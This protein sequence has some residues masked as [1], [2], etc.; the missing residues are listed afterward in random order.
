MF[1]DD[2]TVAVRDTLGRAGGPELNKTHSGCSNGTT[3]DLGCDG[4]R[5]SGRD[6]RASSSNKVRWS[7]SR[8]HNSA[9]SERLSIQRPRR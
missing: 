2:A 7:G 6:I 3:V 5:L 9:V 8:L 1:K 4:R